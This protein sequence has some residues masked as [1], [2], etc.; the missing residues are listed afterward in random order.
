M[1]AL[2]RRCLESQI[3]KRLGRHAGV[4]NRVD[5]SQP[6]TIASS[7]RVAVVGAGLAG[8][9]A[10]SLLAER[11]FRVT[12]FDRNRYLGGK[13]G[14]WDVSF[15]NGFATKVDH[16]FHAFFKH[17]YNL[18][19]F[20][21]KIGATRHFRTIDDYL[22]CAK[23]G[24]TYSFKNV[25]T[26]PVLNILS[27]GRNKFF[28]F[29]DL[30]LNRQSWRMGGFLEYDEA[31]TFAKYDALS[32]ED[33]ATQANLPAS[34]KL[35]FNTFARAF[36]APAAKLSTAEL[37]K[38]FHFFYLSHDH[39]LLYDYFDTDYQEALLEPISRYLL[40]H[41]VAIKLGHPVEA[42]DRENDRFMVGSEAFDHLILAA[43]VVGTKRICEHS[44]WIRNVS[45]RTYSELMSLTP[46]DGYAVYR[47]WL[48]TPISRSFPVFVITEK[49][50]VL[51]SVTFYDRFDKSAA[52]W[53]SV[54]GGGVYELH[55][56]AL[57]S[58]RLSEA[59]VKAAFLTEFR[60]YFPE[61]RDARIVHEHLQLR[62]DFTAFYTGL[63]KQRPGYRTAIPNLYLAGDWV[64]TGMPAML[65]EGA[66]TSGL[67]CANAILAKKGLQEE[68][69]RSVPTR[70][71]FA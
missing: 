53:A 7:E 42:T 10:T 21:E 49:V 46:S 58:N 18:R 26:T 51:D 71:L 33:F 24:K 36:F 20:M 5:P 3:K 6:K 59:D 12:L 15:G 50:D 54:S 69:I 31:R 38:S 56:Y 16:G 68:P 45:E 57:P 9:A 66:Y 67:L 2:L 32:F 62:H 8:I 37:M 25:A 55:C 34:L 52:T 65:M 17:Y 61:I 1:M 19:S 47:I 44:P 40:Q 35:V 4:V 29:R 27:L 13:V 64:K 14:C 60:S 28:R 11:G 22:V 23:D 70:G 48:D 39:G 41:Q 30:L 43:D 63:N